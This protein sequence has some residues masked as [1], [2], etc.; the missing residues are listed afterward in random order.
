[1]PE[2]EQPKSAE[3]QTPAHDA[4][5]HQ[6]NATAP[7]GAE[8]PAS[9][10]SSPEPIV[11]KPG[12]AFLSTQPVPDVGEAKLQP[13]VN[14]P[15]PPLVPLGWKDAWEE[16]AT[17]QINLLKSAIGFNEQALDQFSRWMAE[18]I[19]PLAAIFA[20]E[21][22]QQQLAVIGHRVRGKLREV[23]FQEH[24]QFSKAIITGIFNSFAFL[25]RLVAAGLIVVG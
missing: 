6:E 13:S 17:G 24:A 19:E 23:A 8:T 20:A 1:M 2:Q 10:E 9:A 12:N 4:V 21:G 22:D 5:A 16:F 18:E 11:Q 7:T 15:V 3:G 25:H 14:P